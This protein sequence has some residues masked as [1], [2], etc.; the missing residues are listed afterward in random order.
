MSF[1]QVPQV[2]VEAQELGPSCATSL[3]H[4][5]ERES[6]EEQLGLEPEFI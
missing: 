4:Q 5:Q 1:L 2:G 6:E 3:E